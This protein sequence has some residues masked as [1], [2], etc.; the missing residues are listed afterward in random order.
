MGLQFVEYKTYEVNINFAG[1]IGADEAFTVEAENEDDACNEAIELAKDE[2]TI[3]DIAQIDDDE[4]EVTVGFCGFIGVEEIYT[5][6][7]DS[8][9]EAEVEAL[10]E[11][12][13]DLTPEILSI[14]YADDD[15]E[16]DGEEDEE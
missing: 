2:L 1:L 16:D 6:Y 9:D 8:E 5:V 15:Y 14:E 12:E 7:A 10:T 13:W 4:W 3:E 11:A